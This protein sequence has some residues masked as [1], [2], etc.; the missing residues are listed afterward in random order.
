MRSPI[1]RECL[2]SITQQ[3]CFK[4]WGQNKRIDQVGSVVTRSSYSIPFCS[5][6]SIQSNKYLLRT[7]VMP[8]ATRALWGLQEKTS[9]CNKKENA[10]PNVITRSTVVKKAV[11]CPCLAGPESSQQPQNKWALHSQRLT[12][13]LTVRAKRRFTLEM[14]LSPSPRKLISEICNGP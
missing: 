10:R 12:C 9:T 13:P 11:Q 6:N 7:Y 1:Q 3:E 14:H 5:F 4:Y 2:V 8:C